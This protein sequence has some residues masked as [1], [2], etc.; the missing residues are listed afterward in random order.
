MQC[1]QRIVLWGGRVHSR[2]IFCVHAKTHK[3][4]LVFSP[5]LCPLRFSIRSRGAPQGAD[6]SSPTPAGAAAMSGA[7]SRGIGG[8]GGDMPALS[9]APAAAGA[10]QVRR[11]AVPWGG[12]RR[13][14]C[15]D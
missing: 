11:V 10:Q 7:G 12:G 3:P 9:A 15:M 5:P 1:A 6:A 8:G 13:V 2:E 4:L 14:E